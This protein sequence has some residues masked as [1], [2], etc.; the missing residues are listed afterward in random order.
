MGQSSGMSTGNDVKDGDIFI[1]LSG[2]R[3]DDTRM[4][5]SRGIVLE[6]TFAHLMSPMTMAFSP[7]GPG[8]Y[9]PAPWKSARGGFGQD[10]TA[11]ITIPKSA[12]S[13]F[14]E[15]MEIAFT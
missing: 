9:H 14:G 13:S 15:R 10:I 12:A 2:L 5:F 3:L 11:Q 1:S 6:T 8:G 7:P 4:S